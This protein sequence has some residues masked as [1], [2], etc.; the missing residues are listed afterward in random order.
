MKKI[1]IF[2][3]AM[4]ALQ[5]AQAEIDARP[6]VYHT[7]THTFG[8]VVKFKA[9]PDFEAGLNSG[10]IASNIAASIGVGEL[11]DGIILNEDISD[12]AAIEQDKLD[13]GGAGDVVAATGTQTESVSARVLTTVTFTN[14]SVTAT[15]G[16]AEG[17]NVKVWEGDDGAFVLDMAVADC[18]VVNSAGATTDFYVSFGTAGA[19][20]DDDLTGT[21]ADIIP[22][23]TLNGNGR[24]TTN[25]FDA[26]IADPTVFDG[27]GTA[28]DIYFNLAIPDANMD[29]DVTNTLSGTLYLY[30]SEVRDN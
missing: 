17:E 10:A 22:K 2:M 25:D 12:N 7:G 9:V 24:V 8:P 16:S 4:I 18:A 20:D 30:T 14:V 23:T 26:V 15:D 6:Q 21:E 5:A 29:A 1:V 28:K 11:N 19:G 27:T 13:T 3:F